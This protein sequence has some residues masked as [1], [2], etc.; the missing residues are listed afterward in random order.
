VGPAVHPVTLGPLVTLARLRHQTT[1]ALLV[2]GLVVEKLRLTANVRSGGG[3]TPVELFIAGISRW[4]PPIFA[5]VRS[6]VVR[7]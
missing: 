3:G 2:T 4:E 7:L 6:H 1:Q 5:L